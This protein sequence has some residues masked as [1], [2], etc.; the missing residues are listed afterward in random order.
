MLRPV[1]PPLLSER[2]PGPALAD[3]CKACLSEN[4]MRSAWCVY[5]QLQH[6]LSTG[7]SHLQ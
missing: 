2:L 5:W 1:Q 6:E 7:Q 3:L 4:V